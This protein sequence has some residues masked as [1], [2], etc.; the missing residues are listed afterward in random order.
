MELGGYGFEKTEL[1][2]IAEKIYDCRGKKQQLELQLS[3]EEFHQ[4]YIPK[5]ENMTGARVLANLPIVIIFVIGL[6]VFLGTI[7]LCILSDEDK[8]TYAFPMLG[9]GL[10]LVYTGKV[11]WKLLKEELQM[12]VLFAYSSNPDRAMRFAKKHGI[13]TFQD[14]RIRCNNRIDNLKAQI[15]AID[16]QLSQLEE[17]QNQLIDEAKK[18]DTVLKK[19][20][21]IK[22]EL[23]E[24]KQLSDNRL[25]TLRKD[26]IENTDIS[27]LYEYYDKEES[28]IRYIIKD[29]QFKL[30]SIDKEISMID[31]EFEQVKKRII[32]FLGVFVIAIIVQGAIPGM[33][34]GA[35]GGVCFIVGLVAFFGIER[36]CRGPVLRYLIEIE[37]PL[38]AEYSFK[39][40]IVPVKYRRQEIMTML[41]QNEYRIKE[42]KQKKNELDIE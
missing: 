31:E 30:T 12:I 21:V 8:I 34:G 23:P 28:F 15:D 2:Q 26:D 36:A 41:E 33:V 27:E 6:F 13:N 18:R 22:D 7:I 10:F 29:L 3:S 1:M 11:G 40:D 42:I 14:D 39:N 9:A 19:Y 20:D 38:V 16:E 4:K 35:L 37:S 25:L 24:K 32:I 17:R 5:R